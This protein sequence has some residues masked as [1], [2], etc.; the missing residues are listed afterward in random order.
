MDEIKMPATFKKRTP[1]KANKYDKDKYIPIMRKMFAQGDLLSAYLSAV[2][3]H[4]SSFYEWLDKYPEF[5]DAYVLSLQDCK[6]WWEN[7]GKNG[8]NQ[9]GF[10]FALYNSVMI[11]NFGQTPNRK[12]KI[13][14]IASV[15]SHTDR[16]NVVM[17]EVATGGLTG[18]ELKQLSD[19]LVC[20]VKIAEVT[21]MAN[22]IKELQQRLNDNNNQVGC[23]DNSEDD[24]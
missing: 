14:N 17:Q 11:N 4:S 21:T 5:E 16:F 1:H 10:N 2:Q 24:K 22:D 13:K 15:E 20:G 19:S 9:P 8:V 3:L 6:T 23:T 12:L 18:H 7:L